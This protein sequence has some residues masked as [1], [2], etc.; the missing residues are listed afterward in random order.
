MRKIRFGDICIC[1]CDDGILSD[2]PAIT[3]DS[4]YSSLIDFNHDE[5][6][7]EVTQ[8]EYFVDDLTISTGTE[9]YLIRS[10]IGP[11]VSLKAEDNGNI[12]ILVSKKVSTSATNDILLKIAFP[13]M[14]YKLVKNR[15]VL[16]HSTCLSNGT[17]TVALLG[18]STAGKSTLAGFIEKHTAYSILSD[19]VLPVSVE[20]KCAYTHHLPTK[21]KLNK[22]SMAYLERKEITD[23][24]DRYLIK[25]IAQSGISVKLDAIYLLKPDNSVNDVQTQYVEK[26]ADRVRLVM[27]NMY[28]QQFCRL[29]MEFLGKLSQLAR[30]D[31]RYYE[32]TYRKE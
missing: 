22:D 20:E 19:D 11:L 14:L 29:D 23:S 9:Y 32:L 1:V 30:S 5:I 8:D 12:Q 17:N 15:S 7:N 26:F 21:L 28:A 18:Y 4:E 13:L 6:W 2:Y 3:E 24:Q 10:D 27:E 25:Q 31:V 16:L